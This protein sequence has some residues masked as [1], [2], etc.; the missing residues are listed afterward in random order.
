[1]Q[2]VEIFSGTANELVLKDVAGNYG[3]GVELIPKRTRDNEPVAIFSRGWD[4]DTGTPITNLFLNPA[5]VELT[6]P[7]TADLGFKELGSAGGMS[8]LI[9]GT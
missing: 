2:I 7:M 6:Q 8:F 1:M 4:A 5:L 9:R 3:P